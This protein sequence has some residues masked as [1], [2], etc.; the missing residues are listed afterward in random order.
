MRGESVSNGIILIE[1]D[2]PAMGSLYNILQGLLQATGYGVARVA[3]ESFWC[4][5][6]RQLGN[7]KQ[8]LV[9]VIFTHMSS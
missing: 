3:G 8:R 4:H 6:A 9:P 1:G 5:L 2:V 7:R